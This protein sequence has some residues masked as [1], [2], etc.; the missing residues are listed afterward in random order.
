LC[1][2]RAAEATRETYRLSDMRFRRGVDSYAQTDIAPVTRLYRDRCEPKSGALREYVR[3]EDRFDYHAAEGL[4]RP[5]FSCIARLKHSLSISLR[6]IKKPSDPLM[7]DTMDP[8]LMSLHA[9]SMAE[10]I[11]SHV[12]GISTSVQKIEY[13]TKPRHARLP[14]PVWQRL[15]TNGTSL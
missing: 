14:A 10:P 11:E 9:V 13:V 15:V 12:T 2:L 7:C 6:S 8:R 4:L 3:N 1:R 5:E